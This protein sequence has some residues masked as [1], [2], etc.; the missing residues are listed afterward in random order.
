M[1]KRRRKTVYIKNK[2]DKIKIPYSKDMGYKLKLYLLNKNWEVH[3]DLE[4]IA[5]IV[6]S[7]D[8][9]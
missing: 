3:G 9:E 4:D 6:E 5:D 7:Q 1:T 8:K 2:R